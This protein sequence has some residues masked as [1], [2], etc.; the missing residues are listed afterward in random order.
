MTPPLTQQTGPTF[1]TMLNR[2]RINSHFIQDYNAIVVERSWP[3]VLHAAG[4]A[5]CAGC[6]CGAGGCERKVGALIRSRL[7]VCITAWSSLALHCYFASISQH[8]VI[9]IYLY[10]YF[11]LY[12][13]AVL[14]ALEGRNRSLRSRWFPSIICIRCQCRVL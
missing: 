10:I 5:C 2:R 7:G 12:C 14:C 11:P 3:C 13:L 9:N 4:T 6:V 1:N 8:A